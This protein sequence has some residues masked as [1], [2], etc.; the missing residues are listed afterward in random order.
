[1]ISFQQIGWNT[2]NFE[3][4]WI[5][6]SLGV[7]ILYGYLVLSVFSPVYSPVFSKM[8]M[9]Y[10]IGIWFLGLLDDVLGKPSPKGIKGHLFHFLKQ[11]QLTT[12]LIK[13]LGTLSFAGMFL[14]Y[15]KPISFGQ[16]IRYG[17]LLILIPH[18]MNLVDTRPL[19][20]WKVTVATG[21]VLFPLLLQMPFSV[22]LYVVTILYL[23]FVIEGHKKAMLGDNGATII[24]AILA[25][26][27]VFHLTSFQQWIMILLFAF[28]TFLAE[29]FSFSTWIDQQPFLRFLD[30]IGL[31]AHD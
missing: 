28:L 8:S 14:Y 15:L 21:A 26:L 9:A 19:R 13:A 1:M 31:S 22:L 6:F 30:R 4:N 29:W 18:V 5:P 24:G 23:L 11:K 25:L 10:V 27:M 20:V 7:V 2:K 17:F 12:G 3:G 16:G